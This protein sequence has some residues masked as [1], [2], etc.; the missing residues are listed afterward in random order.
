MTYMSAA[1]VRAASVLTFGVTNVSANETIVIGEKTYTFKASV[2]TTANEVKIG[3]T[4]AATILNLYNAINADA[5]ASGVTHGSLTTVN[6][7]VK[8]TAYDAT[9]LTIKADAPGAGGNFIPTTAL[10]TTSSAATFTST[11]LGGGSGNLYEALHGLKT[12][13]QLNSDVLQVFGN[14]GY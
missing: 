4:V 7:S 9:T 14:I 8:A 2:T 11:V 12:Y 6:K 5:D 3:A 13:G 10:L 1:A